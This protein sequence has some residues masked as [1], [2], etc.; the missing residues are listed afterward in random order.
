MTPQEQPTTENVDVIPTIPQVSDRPQPI[1]KA[2]KRYVIFND[3]KKN[4]IK[5]IFNKK[6]WNR[7][8]DLVTS[9]EDNYTGKVTHEAYSDQ[10]WK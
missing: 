1:T 10:V 4:V 9:Y 3:R 2:P 5:D 7:L 8:K 6:S